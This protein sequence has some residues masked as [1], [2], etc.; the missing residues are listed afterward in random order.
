MKAEWKRRLVAGVLLLLSGMLWFRGAADARDLVRHYDGVSI[1]LTGAALTQRQLKQAAAQTGDGEI[2]LRAAWSRGAAERATSS[3][4]E[5]AQLRRIR[6]YGDMRQAAPI[7]LLAGSIPAQDDAEGCVLDAVSA[8]ALF[9][10]VDSVGAEVFVGSNRYRVRGVATADE[11]MLLLRDGKAEYSNLEFAARDLESAQQSAG[12]FLIRCGILER[13]I[14]LQNG[15]LARV[16]QGLFWLLPG[17]LG[18]A[19]SIWLLLCGKRNRRNRSLRIATL[20]LGAALACAALAAIRFAVYLPQAWLPT[21]WSDFSFWPRLIDGWRTEW[22]AIS[23]AT[24]LPKDVL[25]FQAVRRGGL[26]WLV[27]LLLG[28][29]GLS[30]LWLGDSGLSAHSTADT[31]KKPAEHSNE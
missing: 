24:P 9:H 27:S 1:R 12:T 11:P 29:W 31:A 26:R 28:G 6:V 13:Q 3:L 16:L 21:K 18:L 30:L 14:V 23:L 22:H 4:G 19:V 8:M 2:T 25:F 20:L 10:A 15:M 17:F 5:T 7:K